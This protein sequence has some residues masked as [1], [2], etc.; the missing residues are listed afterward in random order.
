MRYHFSGLSDSEVIDSS[1]VHGNNFISPPIVESFWDKLKENL[2]DP[3]IKI[4]II[5]FIII[6]ILAFFGWAEWLEGTG[7]AIAVLIATFVSTYYEFK[8][9]ASFQ[10]MQFDASKVENNVFR[11][12]KLRSISVVDI[13][14]GDY[15]LLQT[16]DKIPADGILIA[17]TLGVNQ[18]VLN[19]EAETVIKTA[20]INEDNDEDVDN[21]NDN[22]NDSDYSDEDLF[23][24]K[25]EHTKGTKKDINKRNLSSKIN[26][27]RGSVVDDGEG[28]MLVQVIGKKTLFGQL[29]NELNIKDD[30][31]SPLQ[32]K[33]TDLA[34]NIS[35]WAYY[36]SIFIAL[37]Y[38]FKKLIIDNGYST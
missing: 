38:L 4:L 25:T 28:V 7:I 35:T 9:E 29:F 30:R 37:A 2:K 10:K 5:A 15:V 31:K 23:A 26:L 18:G 24:G 16:G 32:T 8:N 34:D 14:V 33:L 27:F 6:F 13:V 22:D 1:N 19:G 36:A 17:G 11:N 3:L 20:Y 21:A 12:G